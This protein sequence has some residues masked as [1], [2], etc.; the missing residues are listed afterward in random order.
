MKCVKCNQEIAPNSPFCGSCGAK[1]EN[2]SRFCPGC[3]TSVANDLKF[4]GTCGA[5]LSDEVQQTQVVPTTQVVQS[6]FCGGCG[7]SVPFDSKFCGT[8][9]F[10]FTDV[11]Q[12]PAQ[13]SA[14]S[15]KFKETLTKIKDFIVKHKVS[16]IIVTS[17]ILV[18]IIGWTCFQKFYDFTKLSWVESYGD[19][20]VEY[21][22]GTEIKLKAEA[23]DKE[24]ALITDIEYKVSA[25]EI[26]VDGLKVVWYLPEEEG[27]YTI[28]A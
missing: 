22:A 27:T 5:N 19:Y 4:C 12:Q 25:G 14:A 6:K 1:V 28:T 18:A 23:Y 3:G 16:F 13:P 17:L 24:D 7:Q 15:I 21:T 9:G 10:V 8:C 20:N 26:E 11:V 2:V